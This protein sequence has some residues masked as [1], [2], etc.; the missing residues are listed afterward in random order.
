[1]PHMLRIKLTSPL[2]GDR[3]C[4]PDDKS[5]ET[6]F[7]FNLR[8]NALVLPV[9]DMSTA[10]EDAAEQMGVAF[11]ARPSVVLFPS[12]ITCPRLNFF[13]RSWRLRTG[14]RG[15][16]VHECISANAQV[17]IPVVVRGSAQDDELLRVFKLLGEYFG[18]MGY[19]TEK[20]FGR[21]SVVEFTP[22][23]EILGD[24]ERAV[25]HGAEP[26]AEPQAAAEVSEE[27]D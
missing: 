20:G 24:S 2:L 10:F 7:R 15:R 4:P 1:M 18:L 17:S 23:D 16:V 21:F 6:V 22:Y 3:P 14:E 11:P 19:G 9:A 8:G 27:E 25:L 12:L 13:T 5:P 26:S